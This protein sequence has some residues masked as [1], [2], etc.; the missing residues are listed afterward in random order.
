M[1]DVIRRRTD[2]PSIHED[3]LCMRAPCEFWLPG[4]S[5]CAGSL[6]RLIRDLLGLKGEFGLRWLIRRLTKSHQGPALWTRP[7]ESLLDMSYAAPRPAW[8]DG[9][10]RGL[11]RLPYLRTRE[12]DAVALPGLSQRWR[13]GQGGSRELFPLPAC[14]EQDARQ[15][16]QSLPESDLGL[17]TSLVNAVTRCL[18]ALY[19]FGTSCVRG[20][21][22]ASHRRVFSLLAEAIWRTMGRLAGLSEPPSQQACLAAATSQLLGDPAIE[23]LQADRTD[24]FGAC[25]R[26]D[27]LTA[28]PP[29]LQDI[30]TSDELLFTAAPPTGFRLPPPSGRERWEY[31]KY[32]SLQLAADKVVL[33]FDIRGGGSIFARRKASGR[34]RVIWNGSEVSSWC[35]TPLKP[36]HLT[37]PTSL[38]WLET[39]PERPFYITKRDGE[40]M[41]DQLALPP[42]LI[43]FMG[44][45]PLR[46]RDLLQVTGW[47]GE[48]LRRLGRLDRVP[49]RSAL[50]FP[51]QRVWAMG[52]AWSSFVC[53]ANSVEV[54]RLAG[55]TPADLLADDLGPPADTGRAVAVATDDI[56]MLS[57]KSSNDAALGGAALDRAL[58]RRGIVKNEKKDITA[59]ASGT[60]IG[61]DL[62]RGRYLAPGTEKLTHFLLAVCELAVTPSPSLAPLQLSGLLGTPHWYHQLR[63]PLYAV[64]NAVYDHTRLVP[65][66]QPAPLGDAAV[67]ELTIAALLAL[68][69][70]VDLTQAWSTVALATDASLSGF[71]VTAATVSPD[72]ARGIGHLAR[73]DD[74]FVTLDA[75]GPLGLEKPRKGVDAKLPIK[76]HEFK[77]V[78]SAPATYAAHSGTLEME[79][80][81]LGLRWLSRCQKHFARRQPFLVD[82]QVVLKALK[83]GRSSAPTLI[84]GI[85]RAAALTLAMSLTTYFVYVPSEWNPAD[86]PSRAHAA[87]ER[88]HPAAL[89]PG[90][91]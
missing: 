77:T 43:P 69:A 51:A 61:V 65:D 19:G 75:P 32:V 41:F 34:Q 63:R 31:A 54:C 88:G 38:L 40:C 76:P 79:G 3:V 52:F 45:P 4:G 7:A 73:Q 74:I 6:A 72:I 83:R 55:F 10:L 67:G 12:V 37:S 8:L 36:P 53:Q 24:T 46:V 89:P 18:N 60:L 22:L 70:E 9:L 78:I 80:V 25:G 58:Q 15:A 27:P 57:A 66:S 86:A 59:A 84:R 56:V 91:A 42:A 11:A 68:T 14:N 48:K 23:P 29:D 35:R 16:C 20:G 28:V 17:V 64:F 90:R 2:E 21:R 1:A 47:S 5:R 85:R 71:G 50:L 62:D 81:V 44:Q 82:A 26:V 87:R 30:L 33:L 39:V 13:E 49:S